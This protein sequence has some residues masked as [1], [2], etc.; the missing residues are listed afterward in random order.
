MEVFCRVNHGV[1]GSDPLGSK[2]AQHQDVSGHQGSGDLFRGAR[3]LLAQVKPVQSHTLFILKEEWRERRE[4]TLIKGR[5]R[6]NFQN[7]ST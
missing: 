2:Y 5:N 4:F 6:G 7:K 1:C 3:L